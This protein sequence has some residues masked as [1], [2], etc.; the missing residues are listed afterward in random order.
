MS[1]LI[2]NDDNFSEKSYEANNIFNMLAIWLHRK[3]LCHRM[4]VMD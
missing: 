1:I 2:C 4:V 3:I